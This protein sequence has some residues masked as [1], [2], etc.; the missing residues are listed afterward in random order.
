VVA[1][2]R[3]LLAARRTPG[4]SRGLNSGG[5]KSLRWLH[6]VAHVSEQLA[7]GAFHIEAQ[8]HLGM[9]DSGAAHRQVNLST[10]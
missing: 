10:Q 4:H 6:A 9:H 8:P 2:E 5:S 1:N 3:A 7:M